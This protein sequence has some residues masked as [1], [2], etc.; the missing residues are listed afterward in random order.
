MTGVALAGSCLFFAYWLTSATYGEA[1][2]ANAQ[3]LF[4][5][6]FG[7]LILI[8]LTFSL[9]FHLANGIRH[10]FWDA[11]HGFELDT[12]RQS[13]WL[14]IVFTLGMTGLTMAMAYAVGA[15]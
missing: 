7:Q 11:G 14:V 4:S 9:Y 12:L 1:A 13:G 15:G 3:S 10:L 5:S 6:W 8:G 2:F